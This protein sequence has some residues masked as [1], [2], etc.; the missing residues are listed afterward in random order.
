[1]NPVNVEP[2]IKH[3]F[4]K[5]EQNEFCP[6]H[7][8]QTPPPHLFTGNPPYRYLYCHAMM[9]LAKLYMDF[10]GNNYLKG[11][12]YKHACT[13]KERERVVSRTGQQEHARFFE[14]RY[15]R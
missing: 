6:A 15:K 9:A 14:T 4:L 7:L 1:M 8:N 10:S 5:G 2:L 11:T 13:E 12:N 3:A